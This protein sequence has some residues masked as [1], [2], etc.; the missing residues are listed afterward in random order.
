VRVVYEV[1]IEEGPRISYPVAALA[2]RPTTEEVRAFVAY[3]ATPEAG[4]V[5]ERFGFV[6]L[7]STRSP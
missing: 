6:F 3:L 1:P 4:V 7:P 5:F 2:G